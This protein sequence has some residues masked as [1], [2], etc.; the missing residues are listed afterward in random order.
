MSAG[1]L[2]GN[3]CWLLFAEFFECLAKHVGDIGMYETVVS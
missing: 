1:F 3:T 2:R